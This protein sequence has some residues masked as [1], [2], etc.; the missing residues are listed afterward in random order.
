MKEYKIKKNS[1]IS[2]MWIINIE[3]RPLK[4]SVVILDMLMEG[5]MFQNFYLG[6]NLIFYVA[7]KIMLTNFRKCFPFFNIKYKP[8]D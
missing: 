3:N 2:L 6:P 4:L 8:L 1:I 5:T 7:S